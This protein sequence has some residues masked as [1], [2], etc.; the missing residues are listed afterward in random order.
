VVRHVVKGA[1]TV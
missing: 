1:A